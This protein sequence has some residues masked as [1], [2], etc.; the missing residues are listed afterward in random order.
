VPGNA[1]GRGI[2]GPGPAE[3]SGVDA[4]DGC[5]GD[6]CDGDESGG[7]ALARCAFS[8]ASGNVLGLGAARGGGTDP[9]GMRGPAGAL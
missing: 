1:A 3:R 9:I 5:E 6:G 8:G 7:G 4:C 2:A